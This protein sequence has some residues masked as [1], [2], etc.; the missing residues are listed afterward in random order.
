VADLAA[1]VLRRCRPALVVMH[2]RF[3]E[4]DFVEED[5]IMAGHRSYE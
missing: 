5:T 4:I 2:A 1:L 3:L